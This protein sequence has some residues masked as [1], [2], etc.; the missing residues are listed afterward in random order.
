MRPRWATTMMTLAGAGLMVALIP[1]SASAADLDC[2]DFSNQAEA[3]EHLLPGDPHGLDGDNDGVACEASPCPCSYGS[4]RPP[5]PIS[6]PKPPPPPPKLRKAAARAAAER[7][8][9]RYLRRSPRVSSVRLQ[10]CGRRSRH[11]VDCFFVARGRDGARLSSCRLRVVVRGKGSAA[12]ARLA[13]ARCRSRRIA[14][15]YSRARRALQ[16]TAS[17]F[18]D[19]RVTELTLERLD[20]TLFVGLGEW[21]R[22]AVDGTSQDCL[23]ELTIEQTATGRLRKIVRNH[24]CS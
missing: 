2:A 6:T 19:K 4:A 8:A 20:S 3:Q 10:R 17:R 24:L 18:A 9:R 12:S 22:I 7:K 14:L 15:S 13:S 21:T 11:R 1:A 5:G 16:S 23:L